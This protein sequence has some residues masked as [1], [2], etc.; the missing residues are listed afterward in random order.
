MMVCLPDWLFLLFIFSILLQ[1]GTNF[2]GTFQSG[3]ISRQLSS[4]SS[5]IDQL[6]LKVQ[7]V[8]YTRYPSRDRGSDPRRRRGLSS[9]PEGSEEATE[10]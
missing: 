10:A 2:Y 7:Q 8:V 1:S 9:I 3:S 4:L 6:F 5:S